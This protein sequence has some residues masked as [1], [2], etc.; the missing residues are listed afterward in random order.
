M[1]KER[2]CSGIDQ[3]QSACL[4]GLSENIHHFQEK[5][6]LILLNFRMLKLDRETFLYFSLNVF[7]KFGKLCIFC[8]EILYR[9]N[10]VWLCF[11]KVCGISEA[12]WKERWI[13]FTGHYKVCL[14]L[15]IVV[16]FE[17]SPPQGKMGGGRLSQDNM[18][19]LLPHLFVYLS[20]EAIAVNAM[21]FRQPHP[22]GKGR[23]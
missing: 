4:Q 10:I 2:R 23:G 15:L 19:R 17:I 20:S 16:G 7:N 22:R 14:F 8:N 5:V 9:P 1:S 11:N 12:W 6:L 13:I 21:S 3:R 18:Y